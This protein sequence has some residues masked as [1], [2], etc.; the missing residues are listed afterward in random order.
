MRLEAAL[1]GSL[2]Q[3]MA[4]EIKAAERAVT[5]AVRAAADGLKT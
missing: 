5:S 1:T 2:K 3:A 4:E